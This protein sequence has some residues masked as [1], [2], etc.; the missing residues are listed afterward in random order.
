MRLEASYT[1]E[2]ALLMP[3]LFLAILLPVYAGYSL[4]AEVK[5]TSVYVAEQKEFAE[6]TIRKLKLAEELWEEIKLE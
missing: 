4:Y 2:A 3:L 6:D 5:N 1:V